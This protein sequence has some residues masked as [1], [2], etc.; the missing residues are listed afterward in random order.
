MTV[1]RLH[2]KTAWVLPAET[3]CILAYF[4]PINCALKYLTWIIKLPAYKCIINAKLQLSA[5]IWLSKSQPVADVTVH[6]LLLPL[7]APRWLI[8]LLSSF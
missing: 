8:P 2:L 3:L 6:I 5:E 4:I 7:A 1:S